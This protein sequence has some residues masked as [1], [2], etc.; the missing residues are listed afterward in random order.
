MGSKPIV[1]FILYIM[2]SQRGGKALVPSVSSWIFQLGTAPESEAISHYTVSKRNLISGKWE[3]GQ[4]RR[5]S[6]TCFLFPLDSIIYNG[7]SF[8]IMF[9]FL[10]YSFIFY[11]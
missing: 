2:A 1:Q 4:Q 8:L 3:K 5:V 6:H 7:L 10:N 9:Y 11:F